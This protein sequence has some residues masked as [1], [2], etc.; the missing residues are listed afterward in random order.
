[1][2]ILINDHEVVFNKEDFPMFINGADKSGAS[3]FSIS[4]LAN[5][6]EN[7]KKVLLFSAFDPAKEEFRKQLNDSIN[8]NALIIESGDEENFIKELDNINDLSDRI[9]LCKNVENYSLNLFN[10]LKDKKLVIFSGDIDRCE[11]GEQLVNKDFNT[12]IFFSYTGKMKVE[13][14]IELPKYKGLIISS[15]YNG[16]ISL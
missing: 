2:K 9:V 14:T 15:K 3:F 10:K 16:V 12:K 6:F 8:E 1:M 5:L 4:F 13:N 7:G 11:F